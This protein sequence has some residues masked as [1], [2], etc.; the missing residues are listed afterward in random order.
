MLDA[1]NKD[2]LQLLEPCTDRKFG[3]LM[4]LAITNSSIT[5]EECQENSS[6]KKKVLCDNDIPL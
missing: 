6:G 3:P 2:L 5:L 1:Y 4:K